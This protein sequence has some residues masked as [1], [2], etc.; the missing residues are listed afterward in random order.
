MGL[1]RA[2]TV[3][4]IGFFSIS[5]LNSKNEIIKKFPVIGPI[6]DQNVEKYKPEIIVILIALVFLII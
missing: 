6:I 5:L 2:L 1:F 3:V 4:L